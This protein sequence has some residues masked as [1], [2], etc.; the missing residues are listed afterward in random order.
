MSVWFLDSELSACLLCYSY[1][2]W[3]VIY[4]VIALYLG[5]CSSSLDYWWPV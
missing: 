5:Q 2:K 4:V 3:L 1:V